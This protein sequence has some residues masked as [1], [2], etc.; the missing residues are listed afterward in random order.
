[1][2]IW[3]LDDND[4]DKIVEEYIDYVTNPYSFH[5]QTS[6]WQIASIA[7]NNLTPE[8]RALRYNKSTQ[9]S[10]DYGNN[11][12]PITV[13]NLPKPQPLKIKAHFISLIHQLYLRHISSD[14]GEINLSSEILQKVYRYYNFMLDTLTF[15]L[16]ICRT[17]ESVGRF[18]RDVFYMNEV[19]EK[20]FKYVEYR[21]KIVIDDIEK[22]KTVFNRLHIDEIQK[23]TRFTS[24]TFI[25]NYN[26][27]LKTYHFKDYDE[28]QKVIENYSFKSNQAKLYY[29]NIIDKIKNNRI[30]QIERADNNG[31]IYHIVTQTPKLL[32]NYTNIQFIIDTKNS[33]P[34]LFNY[35]I[36]EYY[37]NYNNIKIENNNFK[38][39][40]L[41][42]YYISDFI[43]NNIYNKDNNHYFS[44]DL[45]SYLIT[46][47]IENDI[48]ATVKKIPTDVWAYLS[49]TSHGK[50]WDEINEANPDFTRTEIKVEMF[51]SLFYSY[52]KNISKEQ[53]YAK[54]FQK[55]YPTVTKI[56]RHYKQLYHAQCVESGQE[57]VKNGRNKDKVQLA[58]KLM[59]LE[60]FIFTEVLTRLY[61]KRTFR[62]VGIHDAIAVFDETTSPN[63]VIR[64]ME[65]VYSEIGLYP[66]FSIEKPDSDC[67]TIYIE[68]D[69]NEE[70]EEE[71]E[72]E[73]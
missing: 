49:S 63:H 50:L 48:I 47:Q 44:K 35:Y 60:S 11:N 18:A 57:L 6:S 42:Y 1:M 59:Q 45:C 5:R 12:L 15:R 20:K 19:I 68:K 9:A 31:R 26:K 4:I 51:S 25:D 40:S 3:T 70:E 10:M 46:K 43:F 14:S 13:D 30:K 2:K 33:H 16:V 32:R 73:G 34:L 53:I 64:L 56:L 28:V 17:R 36:L 41:I 65:K 29:L 62:G 58:H 69:I 54:A 67:G 55:K 7:N 61:K 22:I 24:S 8:K 71:E 66:T 21:N 27:S 52:A 38:K 37:F 72:E 23:I 39:N